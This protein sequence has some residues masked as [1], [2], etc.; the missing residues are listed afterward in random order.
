MQMLYIP[1]TREL[2][3]NQVLSRTGSLV[4][5]LL[6]SLLCHCL[7]TSL[8]GFSRSLQQSCYN[9]PQV[10][11]QYILRTYIVPRYFPII[12]INGDLLDILYIALSTRPL[13]SQR[14]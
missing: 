2:D 5:L 14:L 10:A 6:L 9:L 11:V 3:V 12:S 8:R 4:S 1:H 13:K 7:K